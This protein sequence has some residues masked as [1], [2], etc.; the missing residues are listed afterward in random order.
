MIVS[1][2]NMQNNYIGYNR[3]MCSY[4][5]TNDISLYIFYFVFFSYSIIIFYIYLLFNHHA[6]MVYAKPIDDQQ[7]SV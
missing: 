7:I 4:I 3:I 5:M 2:G 1:R 6:I